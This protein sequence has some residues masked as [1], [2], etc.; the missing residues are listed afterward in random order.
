M[1]EPHHGNSSE[2]GTPSESLQNLRNYLKNGPG[3]GEL[4]IVVTYVAMSFG[5]L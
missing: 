2:E 5:Q 4:V 1:D 3:A